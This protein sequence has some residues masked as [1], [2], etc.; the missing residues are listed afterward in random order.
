[1]AEDRYASTFHPYGLIAHHT[2]GALTSTVSSE[3][4]T[5][6]NGR[7]GLTGPI[8]QLFLSRAGV[9]HCVAAGMCHHVKEGW[10]GPLAGYGN[11]RLIGVEAQHTSGEPWTSVQYSSYVRGMAV[12]ASYLKFDPMRQIAGHR[13]HQPGEKPDPEFNL[14]SF[15]L[16]IHATMNGESDMT[17][18]EIKAAVREVLLERPAGWASSG[19]GKA[20]AEANWT[21]PSIRTLAEYAWWNSEKHKASS[22]VSLSDADRVA[23]AEHVLNGMSD[24]IDASVTRVVQQLLSGFNNTTT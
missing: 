23:I 20:A 24:A 4:N 1:V 22:S 10:G 12:M 18:E 16:S 11:N 19:V 2:G 5:L 15:R 6:I 7:T 3:I 17:S 21:P 9:W 13:E 14:D 8:S